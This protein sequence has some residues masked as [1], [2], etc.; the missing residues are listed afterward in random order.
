MAEAS[1]FRRRSR[2]ASDGAEAGVEDSA[3]VFEMERSLDIA[4]TVKQLFG[5]GTVDQR[6]RRA[7]PELTPIP[8]LANPWPHDH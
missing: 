6:G 7:R 4:L 3:G 8:S 5:P 2:S 1:R